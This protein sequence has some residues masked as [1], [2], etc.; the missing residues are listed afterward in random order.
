VL[1]IVWL[2]VLGP[3]PDVVKVLPCLNTVSDD[4]EMSADAVPIREALELE[5]SPVLTVV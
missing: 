1:L 4:S 3:P 5:E 2:V